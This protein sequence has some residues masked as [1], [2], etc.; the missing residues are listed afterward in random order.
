MTSSLPFRTAGRGPAVLLIHGAAEDADMLQAQAG[1]FAAAGRTAVWYDRRGTGATHREGW[2]QGGV[3]RHAD[4]AAGIVRQLGGPV[5]VL[6]FSSGGVVALA[7]AAAH[8]DLD[9]D[10]IAWEPPV[11]TAL[12]GGRDLH[13]AIVQ[14]MEAHIAAHPDDWPGAFAVMLTVISDGAADLESEAVARQMVNAEAAVRD[15]AMIIT[16]HEFA[17]GSLPAQRVRLAR[18]R[19]ASELHAG[20]IDRLS[21]LHGLS[22]IEVNAATDHEVYLQEPGVLAGT[23]WS[24]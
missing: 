2:P 14:P 8:P 20:V 12:P 19:T 11:V 22:V 6:G 21:E 23:D 7:L 24:R 17:P 15:D 13:A 3:E 4:D 10:V 5:Q 18:S 9:I 16:R 1:A